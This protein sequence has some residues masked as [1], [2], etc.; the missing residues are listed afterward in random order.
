MSELSLSKTSLA[1]AI[2][3]IVVL[4]ALSVVGDMIGVAAT[5]T[6]LEPFRAM[7]SRKVRGA[8]EAIVLV[9]NAEKVTS[10]FADILGDIC[11]ILAG[12][13]GACISALLIHKSMSGIVAIV[14]ASLVSAVIATL[15]IFGKAAFKK[16]SIVHCEKIVLVCGKIMSVFHRQNKAIKKKKKE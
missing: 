3:V 12:A 16:Y 6:K 14:I 15:T 13:A 1:I 10:I 7:A 5:A 11:G 4:V 8:N 2:V 9:K